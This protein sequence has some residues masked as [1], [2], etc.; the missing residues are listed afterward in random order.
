MIHEALKF[1][2]DT[3]A[4]LGKPKS[5]CNY[6]PIST[7]AED[8]N[9]KREKRNDIQRL[10]K[11]YREERPAGQDNNEQD[12]LSCRKESNSVVRIVSNY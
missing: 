9:N 2:S 8:E 5:R 4:E 12:L 1:E 3:R 11:K 7:S 10:E 6:G